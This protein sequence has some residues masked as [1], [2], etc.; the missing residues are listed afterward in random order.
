LSAKVVDMYV[1]EK[2]VG[3]FVGMTLKKIVE[4]SK[5]VIV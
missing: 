2:V 1:F 5:G 3:G 4:V